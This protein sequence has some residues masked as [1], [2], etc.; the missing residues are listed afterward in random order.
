MTN[1]R[2]A[3]QDLRRKQVNTRSNSGI[4][5]KHTNISSATNTGQP[6]V[7]RLSYQSASG[8][9]SQVAS[10]TPARSSSSKVPT[11]GL[12]SSKIGKIERG[13]KKQPP[14]PPLRT[15]SITSEASS[16]LP[17]ASNSCSQVF[18]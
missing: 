11:P 16:D 7:D 3:L 17:S 6:S 18:S 9:S 10:P 1:I 14:A 5:F 2:N 8:R 12:N 4:S 15:N 13:T